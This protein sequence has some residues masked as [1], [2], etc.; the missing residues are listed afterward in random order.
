MCLASIYAVGEVLGKDWLLIPR[1]ASTH[2]LVN[3]LGFVL[4]GLLGWLV[5]WNVAAPHR[6]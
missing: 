6:S 5:E 2:G 3:A 1:M 4:L